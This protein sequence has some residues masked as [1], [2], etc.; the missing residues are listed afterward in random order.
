[1]ELSKYNQAENKRLWEF[2]YNTS[3]LIDILEKE[4]T[5]HRNNGEFEKLEKAQMFLLKLYDEK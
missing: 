2:R 4:C 5:L 3:F 1:M